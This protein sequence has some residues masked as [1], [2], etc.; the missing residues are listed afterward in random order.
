MLPASNRGTGTNAGFPDVCNTPVGTATVPISY[1]NTASASSAS[2]FSSIV[3]VG[4]VNALN[5]NSK[6][7]NTSGDEGGSAGPNMGSA[8]YTTGNPIVNVEKVPAISLACPTTGNNYNCSLAA[9]VVPA[10]SVVTYS[11]AGR[12]SDD[13]RAIARL[14]EAPLREEDRA[15]P[16]RDGRADRAL[17]LRSHDGVVVVEIAIVTTDIARELTAA[18][19]RVGLQ[20][21]QRLVLDL[22]GCP[23][24]DLEGA[25]DL[26]SRF[27]PKGSLLL[28]VLDE[29]G[30]RDERRSRGGPW[31][32]VPVDVLVD[33]ATASAAEALAGALR[34]GAGARL[35]GERTYGKGRLE[36][37]RAG[38]LCS[39]GEAR[40]ADGRPIQGCGLDPDAPT[41]AAERAR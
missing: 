41:R 36:A 32:G 37:M 40:L 5:L 20:R 29:D 8:A 12:A 21:P 31:E 11:R 1:P 39:V 34:S 17:R 24:G 6:I 2:T 9:V 14:A 33:G 10:A 25:L 38:Q 22:R 19:D 15:A 26:A 18:L 13:P 27:T 4:M 3:Y 23:G 7:P 16:P 35:F 28:V 30:D